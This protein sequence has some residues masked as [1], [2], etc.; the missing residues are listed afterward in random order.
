MVN[1]GVNA[2]AGLYKSILDKGWHKLEK[3]IEK[4]VINTVKL[5]LKYQLD[6]PCRRLQNA[7]TSIPIIAKHGMIFL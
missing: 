3:F 1:N 4:N 5:D 6:I 7:V 2:K